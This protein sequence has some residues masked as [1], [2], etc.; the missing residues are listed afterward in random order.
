MASQYHDWWPELTAQGAGSAKLTPTMESY[1]QTNANWLKQKHQ[2]DESA[3]MIV[4]ITNKKG[5][6]FSFRDQQSQN[7]YR[8]SGEGKCMGEQFTYGLSRTAMSRGSYVAANL[9]TVK[10]LFKNPLSPDCNSAKTDAVIEHFSVKNQLNQYSDSVR[11][12]FLTLKD[13]PKNIPY[14][15]TFIAQAHT[16]INGVRSIQYS[17]RY[18]VFCG[19]ATHP[20]QNAQ[21]Q[22]NKAPVN[23]PTFVPC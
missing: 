1:L 4:G 22:I 5:K 3:S 14:H 16:D 19:L 20:P 17:K 21:F 18:F 8:L 2:A 15:T 11:A 6:E 9:N 7:L 12:F 13:P 10:P 23:P